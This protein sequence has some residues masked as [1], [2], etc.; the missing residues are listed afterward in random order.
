[1]NNVVLAQAAAQR[2]PG[3]RLQGRTQSDYELRMVDDDDNTPDYD[4]PPLQ[5][6]AV[7]DP[8]ISDP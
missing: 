4:F 2:R 1:M 3:V 7:A 5:V 6:C 8:V